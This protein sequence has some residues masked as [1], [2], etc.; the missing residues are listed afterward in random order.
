MRRKPNK[1]RRFAVAQSPILVTKKTRLFLSKLPYIKVRCGGWCER[2]FDRLKAYRQSIRLAHINKQV[3]L[4]RFQHSFA[5]T[6]SKAVPT[7]CIYKK[8]SVAKV[9][10]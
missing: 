5:Y 6:C 4:Y 10:E 9:H 1:K 8:Y 7:C 2:L 3:C